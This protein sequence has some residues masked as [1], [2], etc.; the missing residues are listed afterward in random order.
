MSRHI[1]D[2]RKLTK[3]FVREV[4]GESLRFASLYSIW[5]KNVRFVRF[6]SLSGREKIFASLRFLNFVLSDIYMPGLGL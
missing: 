1:F 6:A 5:K 4:L 3:N 2:S